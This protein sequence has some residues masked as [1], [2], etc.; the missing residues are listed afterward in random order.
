[1]QQGLGIVD[2]CANGAWLNEVKVFILGGHRI[3]QKRRAGEEEARFDWQGQSTP[4]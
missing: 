1:M 3:D 4:I 2:P